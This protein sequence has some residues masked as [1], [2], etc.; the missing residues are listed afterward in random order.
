MAYHIAF[1]NSKG[2]VAKTTSAINLADMLSA[3]GYKTLLID[4]DS[5]G[6][7]GIGLGVITYT[8]KKDISD[9][10]M[11]YEV[12]ED[13]VMHLTDT[14]DFMP[15]S[16]KL[17]AFES[18]LKEKVMSEFKLR[19]VLDKVTD[20]Y[21]Y[22]VI[23]TPPDLHIYNTNGILAADMILIPVS[24][25]YFA[26]EGLMRIYKYVK[27]EIIP[28]IDWPMQTKCFLTMYKNVLM[29][30]EIAEIIQNK[31]GKDFLLETKIR[32]NTDIDKS[33]AVGQPIRVFSKKNK[34]KPNGLTDYDNL[35]NEIIKLTPKEVV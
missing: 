15:A 30:K 11:D 10:L 4:L 9:V 5:H 6:Q 24:S 33:T 21:D 1:A 17:L 12:F 18:Q 8:V 32:M 3:K 25:T 23:D 27:T 29:S 19:K 34:I 26:F 14:L 22:I 2:G 35:C 20:Q 31:F 28:N 7:S 13:V 16:A